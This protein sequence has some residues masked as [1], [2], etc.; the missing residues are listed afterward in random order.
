VHHVHVP[1]RWSVCIP[2]HL[3]FAVP[4]APYTTAVH[5]TFESMYLPVH[6]AVTDR[7]VILILLV[8][9]LNLHKA[10]KLVHLR[11]HGNA[12]AWSCTEELVSKCPAHQ[13][14]GV[15]RTA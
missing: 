12:G 15:L 5:T 1:T 14:P 11:C 10:T 7:N 2:I 9:Q 3:K 8:L 6:V 13:S 4:T